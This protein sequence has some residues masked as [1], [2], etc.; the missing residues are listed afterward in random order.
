MRDNCA[1]EQRIVKAAAGA[2][3]RRRSHKASLSAR[4]VK[5]TNGGLLKPFGLIPGRG[6]AKAFV[7]QVREKLAGGTSRAE[8]HDFQSRQSFSTA[9]AATLANL[10]S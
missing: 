6:A 1:W 4:T 3:P 2:G 9:S 5:D 7:R 10:A 8:G